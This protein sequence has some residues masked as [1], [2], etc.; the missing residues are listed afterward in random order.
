VKQEVKAREFHVFFFSHPGVL[1]KVNINRNILQRYFTCKKIWGC[2]QLWSMCFGEKHL[3]QNV[4][5]PHPL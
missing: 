1:K 3:F 4:T 2:Q 5:P